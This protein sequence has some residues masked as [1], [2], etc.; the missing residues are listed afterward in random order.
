MQSSRPLLIIAYDLGGEA[1]ATLIID[2]LR[3]TF[4]VTAVRGPG[5]GDR[6]KRQL[7]DIAI[8]TGGEVVTA[9]LGGRLDKI[10]LTQLGQASKV[11]VTKDD[12]TIVDGAGDTGR[13]R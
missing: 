10:R 9:E 11:I 3:G 12:T 5:F 4:D 1:L 7:E 2:K 13:I 6:R 8:L